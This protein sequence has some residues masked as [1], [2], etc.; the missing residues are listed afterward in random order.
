ATTGGPAILQGRASLAAVPPGRY[1]AS[2]A[3]EVAGQP[4][5]RIDRIVEITGTQP[6]S[7]T[8]DVVAP[9]VADAAVI[10]AAPPKVS[11]DPSTTVPD[12]I[13][14]RVGAYVEQYG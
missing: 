10:K 11:A 8:P 4:L 12:E 7:P 9:P 14:R 13:L 1:T 5:T 6:T 3:V 2:A